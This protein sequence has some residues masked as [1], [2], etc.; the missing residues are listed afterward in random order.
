MSVFCRV[1]A[2]MEYISGYIE[3]RILKIFSELCS[4]KVKK[5]Q[6]GNQTND[7]DTAGFLKERS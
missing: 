1:Q 3:Q 2:E 4:R 5:G 7:D 6:R